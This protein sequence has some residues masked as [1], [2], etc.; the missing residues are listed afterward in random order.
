MKCP[1]CGA[2]IEVWTAPVNGTPTEIKKCTKCN[3]MLI[4]N[5]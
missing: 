4:G 5:D 2:E 1:E 3:W